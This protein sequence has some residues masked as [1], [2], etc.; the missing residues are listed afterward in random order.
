[1]NFGGSQAKRSF[2]R[3]AALG[4]YPDRRETLVALAQIA[5]FRPRY[6]EVE[7]FASRLPGQGVYPVLP[8]RKKNKRVI[9]AM[10]APAKGKG[11]SRRS[12]RV[13]SAPVAGGREAPR[14]GEMGFSAMLSFPGNEQVV[15]RVI[16]RSVPVHMRTP[17]PD[18]GAGFQTPV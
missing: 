6:L 8:R 18:L 10:D 13:E 17:A 12:R 16:L 7:P 5:G 15:N 2:D 11:R 14:R 3:A 9:G 1:M 4:A